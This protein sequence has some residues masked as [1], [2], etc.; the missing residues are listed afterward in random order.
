MQRTLSVMVYYLTL[1]K[2]YEVIVSVE[3]VVCELKN[4]CSI[5]IALNQ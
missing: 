3:F 5:R 1:D 2:S 4:I